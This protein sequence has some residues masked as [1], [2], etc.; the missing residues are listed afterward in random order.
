VVGLWLRV[1]V[2]M[3]IVA[4]VLSL[5]GIYAVLAFAVSRRTREIGLRIALGGSRWRVLAAIFRRPVVQAGIGIAAGI[6]IITAVALLAKST[7]FP[8][9]ESGLSGSAIL[10]LLGYAV[11]MTG[12][13]L[14][15]CIVPARRA[16][17][18]EPTVALRME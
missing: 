14:L 1:T 5:A 13:C 8:G 7:E 18:V 11:L 9:S 15:A 6:S 12:V 2:A 17:R 10:M 3:S 4:L 16:L